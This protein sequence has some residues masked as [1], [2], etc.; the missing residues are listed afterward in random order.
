MAIDWLM[1][2]R[3]TLWELEYGN[4]QNTTSEYY[5]YVPVHG[6]ILSKFQND[7]NLLRSL[8]MDIPVS[9]KMN[10]FWMHNYNLFLLYFPECSI[11]YLFV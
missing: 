2:T 9:V 10:H 4:C 6:N 1:E 3:T 7:L 11:T 8:T 5:N